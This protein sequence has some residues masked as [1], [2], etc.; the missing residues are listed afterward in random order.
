MKKF[1]QVQN[2]KNVIGNLKI[3]QLVNFIE[4]EKT[5]KIGLNSKIQILLLEKNEI[6]EIKN[7]NDLIIEF[8]KFK[9]FV[10]NENKKLDVEFINFE[11]INILKKLAE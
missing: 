4:N 9:K 7:K 1:I 2:F 5:L 11:N 6:E 8:E 10:E 3:D